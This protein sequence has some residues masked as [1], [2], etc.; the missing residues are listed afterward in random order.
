M[1]KFN[2]LNELS[3]VEC[4]ELKHHLTPAV[5]R[6]AASQSSEA[7]QRLGME[8]VLTNRCAEMCL[9]STSNLDHCSLLTIGFGDSE[10]P[11]ITQFEDAVAWTL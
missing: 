5:S 10:S 8:L 3:S 1:S 7:N 6:C 2:C 9:S 11:R 4:R